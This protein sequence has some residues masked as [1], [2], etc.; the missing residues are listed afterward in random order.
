MSVPG[1]SD[2]TV[3]R[4]AVVEMFRSREGKEGPRLKDYDVSLNFLTELEC[5]RFPTYCVI[6]TDE[7]MSAFTQQNRD[8]VMQLKIV[9]YAKDEGDV[10]AVLDAAIEDAY[11]V[12]LLVQA[13]KPNIWQVTIEEITTDEG[14]TV[15]KPHAQAIQRWG[16]H[17]GRAMR[18]A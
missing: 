2:R 1:L 18:A 8:C 15:A 10:R 4:D 9:I 16:C 5:K 13:S 11:E 7:T 3:L 12:M 17:H 6:V 14:T